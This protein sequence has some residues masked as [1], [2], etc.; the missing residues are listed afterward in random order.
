MLAVRI[1]EGKYA[2]QIFMPESLAG[3]IR[4]AIAHMSY[5]SVLQPPACSKAISDDYACLDI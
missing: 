1:H 2:R 5:I 4:I 3:R